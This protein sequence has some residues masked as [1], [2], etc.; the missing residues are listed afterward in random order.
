VAKIPPLP[1]GDILIQVIAKGY[2]TFGQTFE[3]DEEERT[4]EVRL[5]PPQ[6]PVSVYQ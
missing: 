3:I 1:Q 4:I 6:P 2:Q 5:N